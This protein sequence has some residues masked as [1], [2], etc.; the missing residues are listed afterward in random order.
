VTDIDSFYRPPESDLKRPLDGDPSQGSVERAL[1]GDF[2]FNVTEILS[3]G[4]RLTNGS[5]GI[6]LGAMALLMVISGTIEGIST[7]ITMPITEDNT[8]AALSIGVGFTVLSWAITYPITVG[9]TIY[10]VKRAAGDP[11]ASF[12]EIFANYDR[13]GPIF[14]VAFLQQLLIV[15]GLLLFILPG[16][17]LAIAYIFALPLLVEKRMGVWEALETSRQAITHCW[18]R[19]FGL[20]ML[21]LLIVIVLG[22]LSLMIG[23]VWL[24]PMAALAFGVA[25][26]RMFGYEGARG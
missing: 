13:V 10:T 18:F 4:L 7:L 25:Y 9:I 12:A 23:L 1:R 17:Y 20:G 14:A 3:E 5:K 16:I 26:Y 6:I 21:T 19:M 8:A 24:L 15:L 11:S 22:L 2:E